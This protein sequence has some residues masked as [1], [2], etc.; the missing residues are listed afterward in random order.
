[1]KG[2]VLVSLIAA[3]IVTVPAAAAPTGP[4]SAASPIPVVRKAGYFES[5][6]VDAQM[7]RLLAA[8]PSNNDLSII[9]LVSGALIAQV[10]LGRE[11]GG[12]GVAVDERDGKY[13]VGAADDKLVDINRRYM[14]LQSF[15]KLP[16]PV[17]GV[18]FDPKNDTLYADEDDGTQ[19]FAINGK[20]DKVVATITIPAG[21]GYIAY[22]PVSDRLYQNVTADPSTVLVIDPAS[23]SIAATWPLAPA[24][25]VHGLAIDGASGR[26]FSA[27]DNGVLDVVDLKSGSVITTVAVADR[28]DQIAFDPI[29]KRVYCPSGTGVISVVQETDAGATLAAN[30]TIPRGAHTVAVDPNTHGVW[31]SYGASESDYV[32]EFTANP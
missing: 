27:G 32:E 21:P 30:V 12:A 7:H 6:T 3:A 17:D 16:G 23:N 20:S 4:L 1:M 14:V 29:L 28:V 2:T 9:D 22:D 13:F 18:T 26:L 10:D 15:I 11:A 24:T 31:I 25:L 8:H 19:I 5:M